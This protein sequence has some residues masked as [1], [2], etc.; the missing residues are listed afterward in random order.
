MEATP[1]ESATDFAPLVAALAATLAQVSERLDGTTAELSDARRVIVG[2]A[3]MIGG[4]TQQV[5]NREREL[6]R[7]GAELVESKVRLVEALAARDAAET[8]RR[9]EV[10]RLSIALAL[11]VTLALAAGLAPG[12]VR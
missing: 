11:A 10:R 8:S 12:W 2:Q 7:Q 4:L 6:G 9:R 3:E 1:V 5:A